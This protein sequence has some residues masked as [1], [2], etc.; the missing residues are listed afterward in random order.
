MYRLFYNRK[1]VGD[2]LIISFFD[3]LI[4]DRIVKNDNV[5]GLYLNDT[6]VG[7]NIFDFSKIVKIFYEGEIIDPNEEFIKLINHMLINAGLSSL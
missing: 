4:P 3:E 7:V 6:L 5:V 1:S 2:V